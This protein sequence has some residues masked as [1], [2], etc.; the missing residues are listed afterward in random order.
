MPSGYNRSIPSLF[1]DIIEPPTA[2][3][4]IK[5]LCI[6]L[7]RLC[8]PKSSRSMMLGECSDTLFQHTLSAMMG[9]FREV[10]GRQARPFFPGSGLLTSGYF[11]FRDKLCWQWKSGHA[12]NACIDLF[13]SFLNTC[14]WIVLED[15]GGNC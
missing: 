3:F 12:D 9:Q 7:K 10:D 5:L 2:E 15:N 13:L 6:S 8:A 14:H 4:R 11:P 1:G